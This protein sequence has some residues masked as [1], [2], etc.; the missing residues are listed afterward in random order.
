MWDRL[1]A[2]PIF[3]CITIITF[4]NPLKSQNVCYRYNGVRSQTVEFYIF[5]SY[6]LPAIVRQPRLALG[7][8]PTIDK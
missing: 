2:C 1:L 8:Y 3:L 5:N 6:G 4:H 7:G